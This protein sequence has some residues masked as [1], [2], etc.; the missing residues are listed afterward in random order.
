MSRMG[1]ISDIIPSLYYRKPNDLI[2]FVNALD[3]EVNSL[4]KQVAGI[5]D[6]INVDKCPD[7][8]LV[9]LAAL[10]NCPLIGNDP[11]LWRRQIKNWPYLL[12]MKGTELS[13]DIFLNSIGATVHNVSTFF[14]DGA[15]NL[16][17]NKPE[18]FAVRTHMFDLDITWENKR[19][20]SWYEWDKDFAEKIKIWIER[21]KPFHAEL[22]KLTSI[23]PN[24]ELLNLYA[25]IA[26]GLSGKCIIKLDRPEP[27]KE[28]KFFIAPTQGL[29]GNRIINI[30]QPDGDKNNIYYGT[31]NAKFR[32]FS[33]GVDLDV[34]NE[35]L[36]QFEKRIFERLEQHENRIMADFDARQQE[37]NLRIQETNL[38]IDEILELLKWA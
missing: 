21:V 17:E 14:R 20:V 10:I 34:M 15:G 23:I 31:G 5:T 36:A 7:D 29:S 38:K 11:V 37:I 4:E 18:G 8:K 32:S 28:N 3:V 30:S 2:K 26:Q 1:R 6:L 35:L 12:K 16:T 33:L 22:R 25:G 27:P 13:L 9:Y 24:Q 19:F